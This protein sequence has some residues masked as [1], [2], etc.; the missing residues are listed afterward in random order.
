MSSY[1][2]YDSINMY[3]SDNTSSEGTSDGSTFTPGT[4]IT[5]HERAN[6]ENIGTVISAVQNNDGIVKRNSTDV[7]CG[8]VICI[9]F[10]PAP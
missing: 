1:F 9:I 3:R 4:V 6:D 10:L 7:V 2:I 5:D 8:S